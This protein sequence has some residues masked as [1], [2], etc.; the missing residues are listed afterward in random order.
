[1][2]VTDRH[3]MTLAVK[4][5]LN[6]NT[7]NQPKFYANISQFY[8]LRTTAV[9]APNM[10]ADENPKVNIRSQESNSVPYDCE[11]HAP[12]AHDH[13]QHDLVFTNFRKKP[14]EN[15]VG[16]RENAGYQHFLLY[17]LCFLSYERKNSPFERE[18]LSL[19][20]TL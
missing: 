13:G 20:Q 3:D 19:P 1:M 7:T 8:F 9:L 14:F 17:S 10:W 15:I 11:A 5:A 12:P 6:P 18:L 2:C 4:V 16:K